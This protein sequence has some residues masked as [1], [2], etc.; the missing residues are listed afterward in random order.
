[1]P[2][3]CEQPLLVLRDGKKATPAGFVLVRELLEE[4]VFLWIDCTFGEVDGNPLG[5]TKK[6]K[7]AQLFY[8]FRAYSNNN[9]IKVI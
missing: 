4:R 5:L 8:N 1:M 6:K 3:T 9:M 2:N 7:N